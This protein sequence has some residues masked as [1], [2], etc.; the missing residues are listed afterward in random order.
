MDYEEFG[1]EW[2][3]TYTNLSKDNPVPLKDGAD[4]LLQHIKSSGTPMMV[5][6]STRTDLAKQKL[7]D[8]AILH[9]FD[10]VIG[11][12]Q[13]SNSKPDP[14]IYLRAA[15][16]LSLTPGDCLAL[17]DS[18][19]GVRAAVAAGFTVIQIPDLVQPDENLLK[20][21]HTVLSSLS[22]VKK[23]VLQH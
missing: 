4:C 22:E 6:T 16:E 23:H 18:P 2:Y 12:D 8:S 7:S 20:M 14:E 13:V 3:E 17:E 19:N 5:A 10:R 9:Y 11:G 15:S 1:R 21:G